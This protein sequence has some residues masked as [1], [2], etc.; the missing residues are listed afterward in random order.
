[1]D[2]N[3]YLTI[4]NFETIA[5]DSLQTCSTRRR[6]KK[7][8][9]N[10]NKRRFSDEQIRTLETI[11]YSTDSKLDSRKKVELA[12]ELGL[13]PRQI[14]IWFQ[15]RRARWRSK[16][17]E[18]NF[19]SLRANY[20]NLASQFK[21]LQ[22]ENNS[23]LSQLQELSV[24]LQGPRGGYYWNDIRKSTCE[25]QEKPKSFHDELKQSGVTY[26]NNNRNIN[27]KCIVNGEGDRGLQM[28]RL[29]EGRSND[30]SNVEEQAYQLLDPNGSSESIE[31]WCGF[32]SD[33]GFVFEYQSCSSLQGLS[34]WG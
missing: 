4:P 29:S 14:A 5:L 20:D 22:E 34:F 1:M 26:L 18:N 12:T 27:K 15:N 16:E 24:L 6:K 25:T 10:M 28:T 17:M 11:F 23:L 32:D 21:S 3:E 7:N 8:N 33:G 13:Q 30:I 31:K 2:R 9:N 19:T